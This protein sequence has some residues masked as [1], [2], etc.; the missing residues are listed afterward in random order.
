[1]C[2]SKIETFTAQKMKYSVKNFFNKC[3]QTVNEELYLFREYFLS[4]VEYFF[5]PS[6]FPSPYK[7]YVIEK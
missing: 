2:I 1:M 4:K 5:A 3:Y 6:T 7:P